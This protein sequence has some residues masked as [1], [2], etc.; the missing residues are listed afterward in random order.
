MFIED[1]LENQLELEENISYYNILRLKET[2]FPAQN[3]AII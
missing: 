2:R 3:C 1:Q